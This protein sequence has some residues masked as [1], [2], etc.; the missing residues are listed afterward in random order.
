MQES[1]ARLAGRGELG[2]VEIGYVS[3]AACTGFL[4]TAVAAYRD[5][6]PLVSLS[7]VKMQSPEQLVQL[8]EGR[9]DIGFLRPPMR[10]PVGILGLLVMRQPVV[11]ALPR[12]HK[13]AALKSIPTTM[14]ADQCFIAP[15]NET[16]FGMFPTPRRN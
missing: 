1:V 8:S 4:T 11:I 14:L 3:S 9:L 5:A 2:R 15:T 7:I 10:Y 13:L 12:N 6:H 16:E